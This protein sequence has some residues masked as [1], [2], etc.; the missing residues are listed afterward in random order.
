ME[1]ISGEIE[2]QK[3]AAVLRTALFRPL[4]VE[5]GTEVLEDAFNSYYESHKKLTQQ[6]L[7]RWENQDWHGI[8]EASQKRPRLYPQALDS[9][10]KQLSAVVSLA[11]LR[12]PAFWE[13]MKWRYILHIDHRYEADLALTFF[14]SAQR[15]LFAKEG[16]A[17]EYKDDGIAQSSQIKTEQPIYRTY[18][19][20]CHP[21][22]SES[23]AA[24]LLDCRFH[25][26]FANLQER[27]HQVADRITKALDGRPVDAIDALNSVFFRNKGA[28]VVGRIWSGQALSPF[29]IALR[30]QEETKSI[31][32]HAALIGTDDLYNFLFTST[33][34]SF[35]VNPGMYREIVD[36]LETL[37]PGRGRPGLLAAIGATHPAKIA[38]NQQMRNLLA[39][40]DET[41]KETVGTEGF[42]M[43]VFTLRGLHYVLKVV[44]DISEK[45]VWSRCRE[46]LEL[47]R[48][49]HE[50]DRVGRMLDPW[51][52][53]N[54]WF[55]KSDFDLDL[56][57]KLVEK[58]PESVRVT[59]GEVILGH[60]IDMREVTP[61][62]VFFELTP[63]REVRKN[64]ILD[65][66]QC[67]KDLAAAGV[68]AGQYKIANFGITK[69]GRVVLYDYDQM[70]DLVDKNFR[71]IPRDPREEEE[72]ERGELGLP[73]LV[74]TLHEEVSEIY[75]YMYSKSEEFEGPRF[76]VDEDKDVFPERFEMGW[77]IPPDLMAEFKVEHGDLFGPRWW[78]DTQERVR[79][80]EMLDVFPY[81]KERWL[82]K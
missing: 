26:P 30:N 8:Q 25:V 18:R 31:Q 42:Q 74:K 1:R 14:Y 50:R 24:L 48:Q 32:I 29:A 79:R 23:V 55:R 47:H 63:D 64:A 49:A 58:A 34:S 69:G 67:I 13:E 46:V 78:A 17:V 19:S 39:R 43:I 7:S 6:A 12:N 38:L 68:W 61:L 16:V 70:E 21:G 45:S 33:R 51:I 20:P 59:K 60:T 41:F 71:I 53:S 5:K 40:H 52:F 77:A 22:L 57:Q 66:G 62:D 3:Q 72:K 11:A 4:A 65:Y 37:V 27:S 80:G 10:E 54:V 36:F 44:R 9:S 56:L 28:Y 73:A 35:F 82:D 2:G 15:R 76:A 75:D 81:P